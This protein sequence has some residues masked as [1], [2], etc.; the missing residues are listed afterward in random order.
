[1]LATWNFM[2]S[3]HMF[4]ME[5]NEMENISEQ[6]FFIGYLRK[7][8]K[9]LFI[10]NRLYVQYISWGCSYFFWEK[11]ICKTFQVL[12]TYS[13]QIQD[14]DNLGYADFKNCIELNM[15]LNNEK[16]F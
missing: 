13:K 4:W 8:Q 15:Y 5:L 2:L 11:S 3:R 6:L 9:V 14:I 16:K 7:S 1:M 10:K 12:F